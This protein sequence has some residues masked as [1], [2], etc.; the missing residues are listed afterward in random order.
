MVT[1]LLA[2]FLQPEITS[3]DLIGDVPRV[4]SGLWPRDF[5]LGFSP[6]VSSNLL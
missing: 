2:C 1:P 4:K 5:T 3:L 6:A